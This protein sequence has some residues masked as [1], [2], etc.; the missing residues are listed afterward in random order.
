MNGIYA[1][2]RRGVPEEVILN[3]IF[4]MPKDTGSEPCLFD[5]LKDRSPC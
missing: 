5:E 2:K 4:P 3:S 1:I